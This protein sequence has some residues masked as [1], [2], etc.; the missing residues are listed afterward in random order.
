M[1][2]KNYETKASTFG[3]IFPNNNFKS[4]SNGVKFKSIS[5]H[6]ILLLL[7]LFSTGIFE[8]T[9]TSSGTLEENPRFMLEALCLLIWPP[10]A[11]PMPNS[12]PQMGHW[13]AFGLF[14]VAIKLLPFLVSLCWSWSIDVLGLLW[15]ALWP[16]RAW[17][18]GNFRLQV[19]H[20]NTSFGDEQFLNL[21]S[22]PHE[23]SMRNF[24]MSKPF[25]PNPTSSSLILFMAKQKQ[26]TSWSNVSNQKQSVV[27]DME[28]GFSCVVFIGVWCEL[29]ND[30]LPSNPR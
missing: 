29:G 2:I 25:I 23:S 14:F 19:L 8:A 13:C 24:S 16:P 18:D 11:C 15:L 5:K 26:R 28:E 22:M 4:F 9:T 21:V 27:F 1:Y 6:I 7:D 20:S 12:R 30:V 17:N 10:R 3:A